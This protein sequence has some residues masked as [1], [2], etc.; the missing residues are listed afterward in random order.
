MDQPAPS[1]RTTDR[2]RTHVVLAVICA[3]A[4]WFLY[5]ASPVV[6]RWYTADPKV[7]QHADDFLARLSLALAYVAFGLLCATLSI[8]PLTVMRRGRVAA[9][10]DVRRD[11]SIWAGIVS[12]VHGAVGLFVHYRGPGFVYYKAW[13]YYFVYPPSKPHTIPLRF[14]VFGFSNHTGVIAWLLCLPL[15]AISNDY[16]LRR[17]GTPRWK[18]LQR[19]NYALCGVVAIHSVLYQIVE[20]R[21]FPFVMMFVVLAGWTCVVQGVGY[22]QFRKR[23][24]LGGVDR[25][26][27]VS[28][29]T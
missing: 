22:A 28:A 4:V 27:P 24:A 5:E 9:H 15:L 7:L 3:C 16:A 23:E 1:T 10:L 11:V 26:V 6:Y 25:D 17:L 29:G 21:P 19:W 20:R 8:G 14:D 13:I 18:S 2:L 12:V